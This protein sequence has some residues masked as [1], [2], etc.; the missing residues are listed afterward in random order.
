MIPAILAENRAFL[1]NKNKL[2]VQ[3]QH[4]QEIQLHS[5]SCIA[6]CHHLLQL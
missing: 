6:F 5:S 2:V 3:F 4:D 1:V